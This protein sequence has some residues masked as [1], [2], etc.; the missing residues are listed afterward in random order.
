MCVV[1][2]EGYGVCVLGAMRGLEA[3]RGGGAGAAGAGGGVELPLVVGRD[4]AGLVLRAGPAARARAGQHVW[5]VLPPHWPG[6]HRQLL[7]VRDDWAGAAPQRLGGAAAGGAL[8]AGLTA[9]AALRGAGLRPGARA[10]GAPRV[11]LLGLG[12][13]NQAALQLLVHA[14]VRVRI[15]YYEQHETRYSK[16]FA[17]SIAACM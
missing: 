17:K 9:C 16:A 4:F 10:A 2:A 8:Y 14:G 13:V 11:L 7:V 15:H 5:G 6:A 3:V 12:A 1:R